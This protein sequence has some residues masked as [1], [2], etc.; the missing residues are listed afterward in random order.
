MRRSM[1]AGLTILGFAVL[2]SGP[3]TSGEAQRAGDGAL[4]SVPNGYQVGVWTPVSKGDAS[5]SGGRVRIV[6]GRGSVP[7]AHLLTAADRDL[8]VQDDSV[9][10]WESGP[11]GDAI[12]ELEAHTRRASAVVVVTAVALRSRLTPDGRWIDSLLDARVEEILKGPE[13]RSAV[14]P[15]RVAQMLEIPVDGGEIAVGE[16]QKIRARKTW[17]RLPETGRRY[18]Y[19]VGLGPGQVVPFSE[20]ATFEIADDSLRRLQVDATASIDKDG[21]LPE[22]AFSIIRAAAGLP[23][24][25]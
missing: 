5:G 3:K 24:L 2:V 22:A 18:L 14:F 12:A 7:L 9:P 10:G 16:S 19:F 13:S 21:I 11:G 1:L 20:S 4:R 23:R 25:P 8:E 17:V 6:R 15:L